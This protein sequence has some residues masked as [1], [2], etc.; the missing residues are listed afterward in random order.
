MKRLTLFQ[1]SQIEKLAKS[2]SLNK[3]YKELSLPKSTV[4][5]WY[6]NYSTYVPPKR[7][8][9]NMSSDDRVGEFIGAFAG[10]GNYTRDNSY[11]HQIRIYINRKDEDYTRHLRVLMNNIF[12]KNPA[13]FISVKNN[14]SVLRLV[15]VDSIRFI[16]NYVQWEHTK[17]ET[18]RL[19]PRARRTKAFLKGFLR[20]LMDTDG[21]I[22]KKHHTAVFSTI[23]HRLAIDIKTTL[24]VLRIE[25]RFYRQV[26]K[27]PNFKP[28]F[29][30]VI[31]RDFSRFINIIKP[32]HA[33]NL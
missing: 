10:D 4:Q 5:Y 32:F 6:R 12:G 19:I 3:I 22:N 26:D 11:K 1:K 33:S 25:Y 18:I 14:V 20:G 16:R 27:R 31:R 28:I 17:T 30:V 9:F 8:K 15:S 24:N 13:V 7:I 21:Y 29:R 23:S 2:S